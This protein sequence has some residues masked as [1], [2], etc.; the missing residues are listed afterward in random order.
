M[1]IFICF[2]PLHVLISQRII[3]VES[4]KEYIFIYFTDFDNEKNQY[5]YNK[6]SRNSIESHYV[7]LDKKLLKDVWK[8]TKIS[9]SLKKYSNLLYYSG[10]I[11]SSHNRLLMYLTDYKKF[12]T[13]DDGSGNISR[14]G[15]FYDENE[16]LMF[17]VFFNIFNKKLLYKNIKVNNC[18]HYTIFDAPN[19]FNHKKFIKLFEKYQIPLAE[20]D[21]GIVV[22]L[23]NAFA[24]DNEMQLDDEIG[25]YEKIIDK[26]SVTHIIKHPREEY[27]KI[28]SSN[29]RE[30]QSMK[31]SEE[32][33][34]ELS[35]K[36]DITVIGIFSTTLLNL[37][38]MNSLKLININA[39][40]KKPVKELKLLLKQ[41]G[42]SLDEI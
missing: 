4:I 40:V 31:I 1:R 20:N 38:G 25:L 37:A 10:K 36:Y 42:V 29:I 26:Y 8:I 34:Y 2:T 30:L 14:A 5:Y 13:F 24:E 35:F 3:E 28:K 39:H 33:I 21:N 15:Y 27:S 18:K 9:K 17:K 16:N 32:L 6:L 22:L 19:V 23:T 41:Y 12:Y 7:V 11:K